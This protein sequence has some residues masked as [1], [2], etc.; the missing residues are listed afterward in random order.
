MRNIHHRNLVIADTGYWVALGNS[1]DRFHQRAK[2]V[3]A[4]LGDAP[5]TTWPV[6]T[7]TS[8]L[9]QRSGGT[10]PQLAFLRA[11]ERGASQIFELEPAHL[12]RMGALIEKYQDLPMDLADASLV[13]LAETLGHGRILSTDLRDFHSYRWKNREPFENLLLPET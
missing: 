13:I 7:E 3:M 2:E 5:V 12:P 10:G 6:I 4:V 11:M 8:Y 1:N 9:L